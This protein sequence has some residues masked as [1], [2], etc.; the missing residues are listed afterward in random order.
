MLLHVVR[1]ALHASACAQL[2]HPPLVVLGRVPQMRPVATR[3]T[4]SAVGVSVCVLGTPVP[5][6]EPC[7]NGS[8]DPDAVCGQT[9]PGPGNPSSGGGACAID[10]RWV[11]GMSGLTTDV[12]SRY[13]RM[14]SCFIRLQNKHN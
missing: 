1:S 5:V 14:K 3:V 7:R 13:E 9:P 8:T 10:L 11:I 12:L 6:G 2:S 4:R